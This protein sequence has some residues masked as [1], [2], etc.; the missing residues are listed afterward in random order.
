[1]IDIQWFGHSALLLHAEKNVYIDPFRIPK[2]SGDADIIL[3][4]HSH[5]DHCSIDDIKKLINPNTSIVCTPDCLSKLKN[6]VVKEIIPVE[7]CQ[8]II[9]KNIVIETIPAYNI[10]KFRVPGVVFH[11]QENYWVG[12]VVILDKQKIYISGD[13]DKISEMALLH[14]IDIAFMAV[15]GTYTMTWQEAVEAVLLFKPKKAIPYHYGSIV[16]S[17][18]QAIDFKN[19]IVTHKIKS[20]VLSTF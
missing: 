5:Y 18:Q 15:G 17:V 16:G 20:E 11:P 9:V 14:D 1:M 19:E 3:C 6:L 2:S 10:N 13:T 4:T 7:P 12:Y 8:Q